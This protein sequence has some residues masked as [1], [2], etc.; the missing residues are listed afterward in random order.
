MDT[1]PDHSA[2]SQVF[3]TTEIL[4]LILAQLHVRYSLHLQ[5]VCRS[6]RDSIQ[7]S[8]AT[9][10]ALFLRPRKPNIVYL[11]SERDGTTMPEWPKPKITE[12]GDLVPYE[13]AKASGQSFLIPATVN[14]LLP[15]RHKHMNTN[16]SWSI[17]DRVH[18][19]GLQPNTSFAV[20][21]AALR[22]VHPV[23]RQMFLSQPPS[24]RV[25]V[26]YNRRIVSLEDDKGI[27]IAKLLEYLEQNPAPPH[28]DVG[29]W[30]RD[31]VF[32]R[33]EKINSLTATI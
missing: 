25:E 7:T 32:M 16:G 1:T 8:P 28:A 31:V 21:L 33:P 22:A 4:E 29:L 13:E 24:K 17:C 12:L 10:E 23:H 11:S 30:M 20:S 6:W 14:N 27:T 3:N 19:E 18:P 26:D 5:A 9:K 2:G 15:Y